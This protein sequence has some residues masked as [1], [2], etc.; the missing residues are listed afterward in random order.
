MR[1]AQK[2]FADILIFDDV[3]LELQMSERVALLGRNGSGKTTLLKILAGLEQPDTGTVALNG[4]VAYL[5]QRTT[6]E[7]GALRDVVLPDT[8]KDLKHK[9]EVAQVALENPSQKNLTE[10]ARLEEE[11]RDRKSVV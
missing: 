4:R 11:F 7:T 10:Y 3:T 6:L 5:A 2:R 8:L 9:L 1:G